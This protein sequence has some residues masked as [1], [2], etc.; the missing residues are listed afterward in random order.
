MSY[1]TLSILIGPEIG[2]A[3]GGFLAQAEGWRWIFWVLTIVVSQNTY[4]IFL[5]LC[6]T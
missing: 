6:S 4:T 5:P 3:A 1:F 2:P